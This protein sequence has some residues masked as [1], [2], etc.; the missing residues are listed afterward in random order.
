MKK[1][2]LLLAT[3]FIVH[4]VAAQFP[5]TYDNANTGSRVVL[6]QA[7]NTANSIIVAVLDAAL[8][9][10]ATVRIFRRPLLGTGAQ[11]QQ[12]ATLAP[13]AVSWTDNNV[14]NGQA[15]EYQ[16]QRTNTSGEA[17]GYTCGSIQYDQS[18]YMGRMILLIDSSLLL[19][20][21]TE[22]TQLKKDITG[23]GWLVEEIAVNKGNGWY[24]GSAVVGVKQK[25]T[26]VYNAAPAND[27]P[28][29]LFMLGHIP[30][31]RSGA[32]A[33]PPDEHD[34]N[35]GARG[36]DTYYADIDGTYTDNSTYNPGNLITPLAINLPGDFKWDQDFIPSTL[37]MGF[38]RVDFF[39]LNES[40][41][42][43]TDIEL[44][45]G[46]LN[47]L[48]NYKI[49]A[50]GWFM[51]NKAAFNVGY[52][53]SNDGSYRSLIPIAK[54]DSI[55]QY[56]GNLPHPQWVK[57]NGPFML[58]MQNVVVPDVNEWKNIG[59][60]ATVFSS[61]QSYYGF[62]DVA[63]SGGYSKIRALL[64]ADT[65]N[66]VN[67]W[68]TTGINIFHQPG[69]G[70]PFGLACKPIMDH[71]ATNK[72]LDKPSQQYDTPDWWN[73]THFQY[74]GDPTIRLFQVHPPTAIKTEAIINGVKLSWSKPGS[75]IV[76]GYH[77]YTSA[78][79]LG[80][81]ERLTTA[82]VTDTFYT[83][84]NPVLNN[85]YMIRAVKLQS[86]GSGTY[87]NPS[88]GVTIKNTLQPL[89]PVIDEQ[90]V[91]KAIVLYPNPAKDQ[92]QL[93]IKNSTLKI[94]TI[95]AF[96]KQGRRY[97]LV[98]GNNNI[99][100]LRHLAAGIYTIQFNTSMGTVTKKL[101]RR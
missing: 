11:W 37:E 89:P 19:P 63:E 14:A 33:Y 81:Y 92:V 45:R 90:D 5:F 51:G 93:K 39:E 55:K 25:I 58:Y 6:A 38:G 59:M 84:T 80:K 75:S 64:A 62:G 42:A 30:M 28:K 47:R 12:V 22:I 76:T 10:S 100:S 72:I 67:L 46:Y 36:A 32:N 85:W 61:D 15:W 86:T 65:K 70:V 35:K 1:N 13:G 8:N 18:G 48:H 34:E 29:L 31:P 16:L 95:L 17:I 50:P 101:F 3:C 24:S 74:H 44:T 9:P 78:T 41:A 43:T 68:T 87:L 98:P 99:V 49:V 97:N 27:K 54:A 23:D 7:T 79:E 2:I 56:S 71:N 96:D 66:L 83:L 26:A 52:D 40:F 77:I 60:N 73:R 53:N 82:P 20:L 69:A 57:N 21:A 4:K 94:Q 91:A 88:L